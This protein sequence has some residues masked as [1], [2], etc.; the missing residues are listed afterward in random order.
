[1]KPL[2][3]FLNNAPVGGKK[4]SWR[5]KNVKRGSYGLYIYINTHSAP[6]SVCLSVSF[7]RPPTKP[8]RLSP[9]KV[10]SPSL[11]F[12]GQG[13]DV[14]PQLLVS[15][16]HMQELRLDNQLRTSIL[17]LVIGKCLYLDTR[18][19]A[20]LKVG[21]SPPRPETDWCWSTQKISSPLV[22]LYFH[23][24]GWT[25][26]LKGLWAHHRGMSGKAK[27]KKKKRK[28]TESF[29]SCLSSVPVTPWWTKGSPPGG[30]PVQSEPAM[31][32]CTKEEVSPPTVT[33]IKEDKSL[34]W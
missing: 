29:N 23:N 8:S 24:G 34:R 16:K 33:R 14:H 6:F 15:Q 25:K 11:I 10:V 27:G 9:S 32:P 3:S 28:E 12:R 31:W 20:L 21:F 4:L 30:R 22:E 17:F 13:R 26:K 2:S 19:H 5:P 1:M 7:T 18:V